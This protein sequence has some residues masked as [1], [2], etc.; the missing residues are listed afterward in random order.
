M[1]ENLKIMDLPQCERPRERLFKY[2]VE[3]LSNAELLSIIL[4]SGSK[5][6]NVLNLSSKIIKTFGGLN[7]LMNC[8]KEELILLKGIGETK[9]SQLIAVGEI[10]KRFKSY[11]SGDSYKISTPKDAADIVMESMRFLKQ[12]VLK[13]IM[14]NVKNTVIKIRDVSMGSINSSIVH[15]REVFS[16]AIKIS[17]ASII[18]CHNH[19]SGDPSPSSEDINITHRLK[20]C[21]KILGIELVDHLIIGDGVYVSLKEKGIL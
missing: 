12:E 17:S 3:C 11:K 19:P 15:P 14:L 18:I 20:E 16:E 13:V 2:G 5:N 4:R 7:G 6:E 8:S 10:S 1:D 21:G 9:A